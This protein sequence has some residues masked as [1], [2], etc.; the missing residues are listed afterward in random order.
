L[1]ERLRHLTTGVAIYGAG[2]A[3]ISVVNFLL[4]PLYVRYLTQADYGALLILT[5]VETF[6]K[7][8]NRWGLDGAF[9]RYYLDREEGLV[10]ARFTSTIVIF[11][12]VVDGLLLI[13]GLA[14]ASP[15]SA[16]LFDGDLTYVT[17]LRLMLINSFLLAFTFVPFHVM[18]L[19]NNAKAYSALTFAR[20]AGQVALRLIFIIALGM[21]VTGVYVTDL[22]ITIA[23]LPVLWRWTHA[24]VRPVFSRA[25]LHV[26]LRF[27]LPRLPSGL[28]QQVF[29]SGN[30]LLFASYAPLGTLGVY[31]NG[32]TLGTAVKFYVASF[33]TA[34]APFYYQTA[35]Q[36]DAKTVLAKMTTYGVV[37]LVLL[38][39]GTAAIARDLVHLMLTPQYLEAI[40]IVPII[41]IGMALQGLYLLT[42]IGLNVTSHTE[43]YPLTTI[44]AAAVGLGAGIILMP[45]LG[46]QGAAWAFLVSFLVQATLGFV[47]ARRFYPIPYEYGRLA[48][49]LGVGI[50]SAAVPLSVVPD[51]RP[52]AGVVVR[53]SVT[54]V[55]FAALL[56]ASG[57]F[58]P[59]E[60]A[61][62]RA[63]LARLKSRGAGH[64]V[65]TDVD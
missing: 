15:L 30:K 41:A 23:L 26:A 8:V 22:V 37:V 19:S 5:S 16:W 53:G 64:R 40:P 61:F 46:A 60:R 36:P 52:L 51:L 42:S 55:V 14:G 2:D 10:R 59:S 6:L 48:R 7:L 24:V 31:N 44:A 1:R 45:R 49:V 63:T 38:A 11:I 57:F 43:Y 56:W 17:P 65:V 58:R 47:F 25:D 3:A 33:E 12:A 13:A 28:A 39:A 32:F 4:L 20:S 35:K 50:V 34:W 29:D 62:L 21:G 18:R 27:A 9:M 54:V